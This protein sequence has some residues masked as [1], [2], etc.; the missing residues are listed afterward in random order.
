M[1]EGY[2]WGRMGGEGGGGRRLMLWGLLEPVHG[3]AVPPSGAT[4]A[5]PWASPG[6]QVELLLER[7]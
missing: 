1:V 6:A 7:L 3:C 4:V 5:Q 2:F